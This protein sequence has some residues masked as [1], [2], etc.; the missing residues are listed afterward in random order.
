M[1]IDLESPVATMTHVTDNRRPVNYS[2]TPPKEPG[3]LNFLDGIRGAAALWVLLA[4]CMIW[5]GW[6]GISLPDPKIAVDIFMV[7]SGYLMFYLAY[8]RESTEPLDR[9]N[10]AFKFYIRRFFRIAPLYY[11]ILLAAFALLRPSWAGYERLNVFNRASDVPFAIDHTLSNFLMHATFLFGLFPNYVMSSLLPDWSISLEMQFYA[12]F[13]LWLYIFRRLR[14]ITAALLIFA[15]GWALRRLI[16][17]YLGYSAF[18]LPSVLPLK[19]PLFLIGMLIASANI[20]WR[21]RPLESLLQM[22]LAAM[23]TL[24]IIHGIFIMALTGLIFLVTSTS[25]DSETLVVRVR[26]GLT[27]LL[28]NRV[29]RFMA[30]VSYGV[31]LVHG[32]FVSLFGGWLFSQPAALRLPAATRVLILTTVT[33]I[34][35]YLVAWI[36]HHLLEKPG[37]GLGRKIIQRL[38]TRSGIR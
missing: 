35:T 31:Y 23:F 38:A 32:F 19:A 13:P 2:I 11:F 30:D 9:W 37:I 18:P 6:P 36:I 20:E 28:G 10:T 27:A 3:H 34:G 25:N 33:L 12:L 24:R 4:H 5:G 8:Q 16:Y 1:G 14:P 22:L 17:I 29:T 21:R 26:N 7:V 15:A